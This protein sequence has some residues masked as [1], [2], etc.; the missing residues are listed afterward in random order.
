[1]C[2]YVC[3]SAHVRRIRNGSLIAHE[4]R[5]TRTHPTSFQAHFVALALGA[6]EPFFAAGFATAFSEALGGADDLGPAPFSKLLRAVLSTAGG[7]IST[8]VVNWL[9]HIQS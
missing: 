8:K 3:I 9:Q 2:L 5:F 4:H 1:M 6:F 7:L